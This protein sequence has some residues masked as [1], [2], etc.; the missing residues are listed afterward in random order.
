MRTYNRN[1]VY[2]EQ[3]DSCRGVFLDFGEL[4]NLLQ[5]ENRFVQQPPPQ[6]YGP[7][8]GNHGGHHYRRKGFGGLFFSS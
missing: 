7:G 8:W 3:C 6:S 2:I 4:E 5:L 1:G